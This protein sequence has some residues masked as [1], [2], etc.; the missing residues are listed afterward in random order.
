MVEEKIGICS[1]IIYLLYRKRRWFIVKQ[2]GIEYFDKPQ[3]KKENGNVLIFL[4][5]LM[6]WEKFR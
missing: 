4:R 3:V 1:I 2:T 6:V 5:V